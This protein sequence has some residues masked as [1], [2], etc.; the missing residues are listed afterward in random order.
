MTPRLALFLLLTFLSCRIDGAA[1]VQKEDRIGEATQN[2]RRLRGD[3]ILCSNQRPLT[4]KTL[5][6]VGTITQII[7]TAVDV[8]FVDSPVPELWN[9]LEVSL[10]DG[11]SRIILEVAEILSETDVRTIAMSSTDGLPRGAECV[12]TGK[13]IQVP[14]GLATLGRIVN[15]LGET[16]DEKGPLSVDAYAPIHQKNAI[17]S[18]TPTGPKIMLET[19]I[20]AIDLLT[21][22]TRGGK[23]GLVGDVEVDKTAI[24]TN[25]MG[26]ITQNGGTSVVVGVGA[27]EGNHLY[28]KMIEDGIIKIS[29]KTGSTVGSSAALVYGQMDDTPGA[30]ARLTLTG[31]A[32]AKCLS[33]TRESDTLLFVDNTF[34]FAQASAAVSALLGQI[35]P[36][37]NYQSFLTIAPEG[38]QGANGAMTKGAVTLI[39]SIHATADDLTDP[40]KI[41]ELAGLDAATVLSTSMTELGIFPTIDPLASTSAL[42]SAELIDENHYQVA[43]RVK[44]ILRNYISTKAVKFEKEEAVN[45]A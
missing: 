42:L 5:E 43:K 3:C 44:E 8:R 21:P 33:D 16:V 12:D 29:E 34:R 20:K 30:C 7:D 31:L 4:R 25:F 15:V 37:D 23:I 22:Y 41:A 38:F 9:A 6:K 11:S 14:V 10:P 18:E 27:P 19:G 17:K 39:R 28:N 2:K 1:L 40:A 45:L 24:M 13:P 36:A 35:P 26:S 32:M